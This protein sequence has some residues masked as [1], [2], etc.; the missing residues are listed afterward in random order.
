MELLLARIK[1]DTAHHIVY[2][3]F[4]PENVWAKALYESMGFVPDGRIIGG[5]IVYRLEY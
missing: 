1:A 3:S 4:E 2:I 5:E